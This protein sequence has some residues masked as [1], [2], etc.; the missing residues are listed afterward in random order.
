MMFLIT[1][2][3]LIIYNCGNT[4]F[5]KQ[6][7]V[8]LLRRNVEQMINLEYYRQDSCPFPV[9]NV[10]KIVGVNKPDNLLEDLMKNP[11]NEIEC[12]KIIFNAYKNLTPLQVTDT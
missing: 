5:D 4:E 8:D 2:I 1:R 12:A 10:L 11:Q 6:A 3:C 7:Q 9:D